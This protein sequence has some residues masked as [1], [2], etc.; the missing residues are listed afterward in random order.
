VRA[1]AALLVAWPALSH[2]FPNNVSQ[3]P[4]GQQLSC[5]LCH[6]GGDSARVTVFG[7]QVRQTMSGTDAVWSA[8]YDADADCDGYTNGEELGDAAGTWRTGDP[9]PA[10]TP[11]NPNDG[12]SHPD[13]E[14]NPSPCRDAAGAP[15]GPIL[16]DAPAEL[17]G[18][19][20]CAETGSAWAAALLAMAALVSR[21]AARR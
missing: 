7:E 21:R 3:V 4:N 19:A 8:V 20:G 18:P 10:V 9:A 1:A 11:T 12:A 5:G 14:P 15:A 16:A 17:L 2:A 13:G 6:P